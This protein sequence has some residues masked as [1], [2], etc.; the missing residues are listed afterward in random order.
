MLF[1]RTSPRGAVTPSREDYAPTG[2][3]LSRWHLCQ[4]TLPALDRPLSS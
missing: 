4:S 2:Y 1:G 3:G